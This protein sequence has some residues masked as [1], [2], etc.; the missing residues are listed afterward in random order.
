[1]NHLFQAP[2]DGLVKGVTLI[3]SIL[4]ISISLMLSFIINNIFFKIDI[5]ILYLSI[6]II[7]YLWAPKGYRIKDNV[8]TVNRLI[9]DL[10]ILVTEEPKQWNWT[11]WGLRL[12]G[13]GGLYGYYGLFTFRKTGRVYMHATNR[14][15]LILIKDNKGKRY[16]LSPDDPIRF[17]QT[18][19]VH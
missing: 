18:I 16:L 1:M 13:S 15:N 11:W 5:I 19:H 8:V 3:V 17:I 4:L 7:P 12:F 14:H 9:G 10:K 6:L 2:W